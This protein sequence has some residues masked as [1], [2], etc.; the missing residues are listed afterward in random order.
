MSKNII[1]TTLLILI[2]GCFYY[3]S[4]KEKSVLIQDEKPVQKVAITEKPA[5]EKLNKY[6]NASFGFSFEYAKDWHVGSDNLDKGTLQ[7][8]NFDE[9]LS[10]GS[11][12]KVGQN[13]I[14]MV[15]VNTNVSDYSDIYTDSNQVV[16]TVNVAGVDVK[17]I[18]AE[19]SGGEKMITYYIPLVKSEGKFLSMTIYGDVNNFSAIDSIAS[20]FIQ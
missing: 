20:S 11:V 18:N 15:V 13:K 12:F 19:L 2:V 16:S 3:F 7:L 8:F 14:E 9:N 10:S 1:F 4:H 17:K 5:Q 6:E